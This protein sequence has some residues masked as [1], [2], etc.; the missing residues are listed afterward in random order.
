MGVTCGARQDEGLGF[1]GDLRRAGAFRQGTRCPASSRV[2]H[3]F[4]F[5][6]PIFFL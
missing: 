3:S 6:L 5:S 2:L 4:L 1:E